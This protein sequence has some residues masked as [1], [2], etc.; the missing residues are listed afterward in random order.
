MISHRK[1]QANRRNAKKSTG[2]RTARGK[3]RVSQNSLTHGL[4]SY[5]CPILPCE[6][7]CDYRILADAVVRDL[8]P[9]GIL[10][11]EIVDHITQL[12]WKL[13]RIPKIEAALIESDAH[14]VQKFHRRKNKKRNIDAELELRPEHLIA[15]QFSSH[16]YDRAYE[17]LENYRM[18]LERGLQSALRQLHTLRTQTQGQEIRPWFQLL[19]TIHDTNRL[20]HQRQQQTS[21]DRKGAGTLSSSTDTDPQ[22]PR[23]EHPAP[24]PPL[25]ARSLATGFPHG[26]SPNPI[27]Q[28]KPTDWP[29]SSPNDQIQPFENPPEKP[30]DDV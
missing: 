3:K 7:E 11:R 2:P 13:R 1:L 9:T 21:R 12:L 22:T 26:T 23:T 16:R 8:E 17:R 6:N 30:A 25:L 5:R 20:T 24:E 4:T 14:T 29:N 28:S 19:E 15:A 18:R 10:Q 27:P